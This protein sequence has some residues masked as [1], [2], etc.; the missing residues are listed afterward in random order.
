M[1]KF[2]NWLKG[3]KSDFILF[4]ALL[5]LINVVGQ[6][7]FVRFDLTGPKSYSLSKDS[8]RLVKNLEQPLSIRVFFDE[9]LP[10]PY[11]SVAQY[12]KDILIEYKGA[13][14][15]NLTVSYMDMEKPENQ[16][17]ARDLGLQQIQIQEVKN[18]E[19]GFK[20]GY[21][22]IAVTYGDNI[23][24][25]DSILSESGF[26]Y[27]LTSKMSKMIDKADTLAGIGNGEKINLT[28]YLSDVVKTF[29]ISGCDELENLLRDAFAAVNKQNMDRLN[30]EVVKPSASEVDELV[31]RFGI[32]TIAYKG[33]S[34]ERELAAM[35]VVLSY[36]DN[37]RVLPIQI[38]QSFFGYVMGGLENIE[39]EITDALTSLLSKVSQI[40]Y[41]TGHNERDHTDEKQSANFDRL[42]SGMYELVDIDL[43]KDSIPAGMNSIII[44]GPQYDY[45]EEELYKLD[46]FVMKGG[47]IMFFVDSVNENGMYNY[48]GGE[49][50]LPNEINLS[51][52]LDKWGVK[53]NADMVFDENCYVV[54]SQQYGKLNYY[55]APVLQKDQ[56]DKKS[57]ITSNL[58][59]VVMLNEG[60]IDVTKALADNKVKVTVLAKS[61]E[62]SWTQTSGISLNP[63]MLF[64]P[65][66]KSK[67]GSS[68]LVVLLEGKF[69]SA[70]D[71][72]PDPSPEVDEEGNEISPAKPAKSEDDPFEAT[73][74]IAE[75]LLPG[76]IF[77]MGS[78]AVTTYQVIDAN[79]QNPV[80]M[81]LMNAVDYMNGNSDLCT[82]RTKGLSVNT[83]KNT[84]TAYALIFKYFNQFGLVVIVA[85]IGLLVWRAR[86]R[87]RI[88]INKKYNPNDSRFVDKKAEKQVEHGEQKND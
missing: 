79:G 30:F 8:K 27:K 84:N 62:K 45:T 75:S 2:L 50:F 63:L 67:M 44:N 36:G 17:M 25:M 77:V 73:N 29:R 43:S 69:Q 40:G 13:A 38:E 4:I 85:I 35:G 88:R 55:W 83:L 7:T 49:Q 57:P 21:M 58:G 66:D 72:A 18:N 37:F 22:G 76:K 11:S 71:Q 9:N 80:S 12:V 59:S 39:T 26:E 61:S 31:K 87:R 5:I 74:H 82:M 20:Q 51:R 1:K 64:P 10:A 65:E 41:I 81:L 23:E 34:G 19:V 3:P 78:S 14:N 33:E 60:S 28:L 70:F 54:P 42:V 24:L 47:N 15:K 6:R 68:N 56:M 32:Q 53:I 46:Q 16:S 52:L 86:S 48:Y